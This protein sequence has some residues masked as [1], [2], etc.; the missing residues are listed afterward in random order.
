MANLWTELLTEETLSRGW[1]LARLDIRQDFSEELYSADVYGLDL[2]SNVRESMNRIRTDTYQPRP[3]LRLEVPK[4]TLGFRPGAVISITDRVVVSAIVLLMAPTIDAKLSQSVYS[5]RIKKPL[6]GK[7]GIFRESAITDLPFLK[8]GTIR[9]EIDPFEPWYQLWPKFDAKARNVF[10]DQG[11]NFLATSDIA[12][13]F[14]NIQLPILRDQLLALFPRDHQLVNLLFL[15]LESWTERTSDGRAHLRGIPQG[16]FV[17]SFLGNLFLL[18]LDQH[19][20]KFCS[21]K[22]AI[23]Y[24][25]MDDVRIFTKRREDAR[26]AVFLMA[27]TLRGLHLNVQTAK[28]RIYDER[29][30]EVSKLLIDRR[31]DQLS[32]LIDSIQSRK[33]IKN[34]P[35]AVRSEYLSKLNDIAKTD[36]TDG[37]KI[38]GSRTLLEGLSVRCFHR[39]MTAHS[40]LGSDLFVGRLLWELQRNADYKLTRKLVSATKLFPRKR[41]IETAILTF[42]ESELNIFPFQEAECIRALRYLSTLS[43]RTVNLCLQRLRDEKAERYLRMQAAYLLARTSLTSGH[44]NSLLRLFHKESDPYVQ[45]AISTLLVQR[46]VDNKEIVRLLIFHPNDRVRD[47]GKLYRTI[48]NDINAAKDRM[49]HAFRC[50]VPWLICDNMPFVHLLAESPKREVREHL[51]AVIKEPRR[52]H[53][54]GGV[55]SILQSVYTRTRE[56]L[57]VKT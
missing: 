29:Q 24:R 6:P 7:G 14:E 5:W 47:I 16:N 50:E 9:Q 48:K 54:I 32:E 38:F 36:A 42:L 20:E 34:I 51:L 53:P 2:K 1:H 52:K 30:G 13:Y 19:F 43:D 33:E 46:K 25:Y 18:P 41:G 4:S 23:Y 26:L 3:L 21:D 10:L 8:Q 39:W 11:Y 44:L 37:Q 55:R 35:K 17:S 45:V 15:F 28:T 57:M 31:I 22:K 40:L 12:A 56:S 27:R 49:K